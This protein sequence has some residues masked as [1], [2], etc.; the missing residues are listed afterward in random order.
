[1]QVKDKIIKKLNT[2][3]LL[4]NEKTYET[5]KKTFLQEM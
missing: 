5:K 3:N 4:S 2:V 1:M